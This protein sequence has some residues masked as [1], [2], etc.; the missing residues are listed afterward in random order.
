MSDVLNFALPVG[1]R[2][3]SAEAQSAVECERGCGWTM[4]VNTLGALPDDARD[5]LF[6]CHEQW[7]DDRPRT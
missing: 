6:R 4:R 2:I 3:G 1:F 5:Q 7:H